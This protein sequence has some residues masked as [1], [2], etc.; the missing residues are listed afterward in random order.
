MYQL[1]GKAVYSHISV[2]SDQTEIFTQHTSLFVQGVQYS[3][4][5]WRNRPH[6]AQLSYTDQIV[7]ADSAE[8]FPKIN[9]APLR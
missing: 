1:N 4:N 8:P 7:K 6:I 2:C 5:Q 3:H 9:P